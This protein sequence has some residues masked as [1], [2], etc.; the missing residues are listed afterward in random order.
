MLNLH[1][2][3]AGHMAITE[4]RWPKSHHCLL[5]HQIQEAV[6]GLV[7]MEKTELQFGASLEAEYPG[8]TCVRSSV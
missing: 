3:L 8:I 5:G 2:S 7:G 6:S 1:L 4:K